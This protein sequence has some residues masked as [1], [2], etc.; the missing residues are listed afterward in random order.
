MPTVHKTKSHAFLLEPGELKESSDTDSIFLPSEIEMKGPKEAK[1][2]AHLAY[3][4]LCLQFYKATT[5]KECTRGFQNI[6]KVAYAI[7]LR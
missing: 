2:K 1:R 4:N 6:S 7:I 5:N 3:G